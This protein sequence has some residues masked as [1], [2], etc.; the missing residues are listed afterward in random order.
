MLVVLD[1]LDVLA[2]S[3]YFLLFPFVCVRMD[4]T[5]YCVLLLLPNLTGAGKRGW[6]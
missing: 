6:F 2:P 5:H 3:F 1:L 4:M